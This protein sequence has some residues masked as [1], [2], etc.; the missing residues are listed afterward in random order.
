MGEVRLDSD[1]KWWAELAEGRE[2]ERTSSM[3]ETASGL[4]SMTFPWNRDEL[5][6]TQEEAQ[7]FL[8]LQPMLL[9]QRVPHNNVC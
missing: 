1:L 5:G 6:H 2:E 7:V 8:V 3:W 9:P 4:S